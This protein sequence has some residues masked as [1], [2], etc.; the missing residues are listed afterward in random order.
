M[1]AINTEAPILNA[2]A[3]AV[4]SKSCTGAG[5]TETIS[6]GKG[7]SKTVYRGIS[8]LCKFPI[9]VHDQIEHVNLYSNLTSNTNMLTKQEAATI[10]RLLQNYQRLL[11]ASNVVVET[12]DGATLI[13]A[14]GT[15]PLTFWETTMWRLFG[16][17]PK[18]RTQ[19]EEVSDALAD[20]QVTF[21]L[22]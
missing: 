3:G 8:N 4:L 9:T 16:T 15:R 20:T 18:A 6:D 5:L 10:S 14:Q 17:I 12:E 22:F 1:T 11:C 7:G 13:H 2:P 21:P 19:N